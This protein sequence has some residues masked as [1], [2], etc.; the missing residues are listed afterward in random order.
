MRLEKFRVKNFR[1]IVDSGEIENEDIMVLVGPNQA[2]KSSILKGL[3]SISFSHIYD[4]ENDLTQLNNINKKYVDHDFNS[5]DLPIIEATFS[6]SDKD[7]AVLKEKLFETEDETIDDNSA[8]AEAVSDEATEA[9]PEVE[10]TPEKIRSTSN[11]I[12]QNV[13]D[14]LK[15]IKVIKYIDESY[16]VKLAEQTYEF[17]NPYLIVQQCGDLLTELNNETKNEFD[18]KPNLAY[19]NQFESAIKS[20]KKLLPDNG[21]QISNKSKLYSPIK[22]FTNH[23]VSESLKV[24][25]QE[26]ASEIEERVEHY[27][28]F[29]TLKIISF[30]IERMPRTV[31]FKDYDRLV[32]S[33]TISELRTNP[34]KHSA[35]LNLLKVADARLDS[36]EN[37]ED[38]QSAI[39]QYL[40]TASASATKKLREAYKQESF[41]LDIRYDNGTL[42][43]FTTD[44]KQPGTLLPPSYGS[45]GFQWFL[46]FYINFAVA[47][48]TEYKNAILLLDDP[49]VLL[50]PS[51]H[52]DLLRRFNGYLDDEVRTIYSTHLPSLINK[53]SIDSIRVIYREKGQTHVVK[54][55]WK[56]SNLDAWAPIRSSLGIDLT[57]SLFFGTHTIM[58]E[59]PSD[60]TYFQDLMRILRE[61][62]RNVSLGFVLPIGGIGNVDF[63]IKLFESQ[64]LPYVAVLDA[65]AGKLESEGRI[66]KI[67][68]KNKIR[69]DQTEFDIEDMIENEALSKAFS[70]LYPELDRKAVKDRLSA[71]NA[72]A[73]KILKGILVENGQNKDKLDKV[74]LAKQVARVIK[75]SPEQYEKTLQNF[76][77][78]FTG[79]GQK[80]S[81]N[82]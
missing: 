54:N 44:P 60:A 2:G 53:A 70:N 23:P 41:D 75:E 59:G 43:V 64:S 71:S 13:I 38:N 51:G 45:E 28:V 42:L 22:E 61:N 79:I 20:V 48:K 62:N 76:E 14:S 74:K 52:K 6:L 73:I 7:R 30:L 1:S 81:E 29:E 47:T 18:A 58:V 57:D 55:F 16:S 3:N 66:I 31:Y 65:S 26:T 10:P 4:V 72:K 63:F 80:F 15:E 11:N 19:K 50:H 67:N 40:K 82:P 12:D 21:Y 25:V 34:K 36:I 32:D 39:Q 68:P 17:E 49:G 78:L 5:H 35:F 9:N 33:I 24:T 56:L 77:D 46:G 27:P 37:L 8:E 69:G